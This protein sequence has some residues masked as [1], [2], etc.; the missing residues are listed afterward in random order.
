[1]TQETLQSVRETLGLARLCMAHVKLD[2]EE[3]DDVLALPDFVLQE[4]VST[5]LIC[6]LAGNIPAY[7]RR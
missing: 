7:L 1:M 6:E 5:D 4:S 2:T 3:V